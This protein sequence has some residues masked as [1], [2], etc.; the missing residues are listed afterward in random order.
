MELSINTRVAFLEEIFHA[1]GT[2]DIRRT[3]C[4]TLEVIPVCLN[5]GPVI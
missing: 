1:M 3:N 5:V 2:D 4:E